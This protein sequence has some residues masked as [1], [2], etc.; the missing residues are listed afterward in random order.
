MDN[1]DVQELLIFFTKFTPLANLE[2]LIR[3]HVGDAVG[4]CQRC[5]T[6]D[7]CTLHAVGVLAL[8]YYPAARAG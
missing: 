3:E 7:R 8:S 2:K 1:T 6:S 4:R 5:H